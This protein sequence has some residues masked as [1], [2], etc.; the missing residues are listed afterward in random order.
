M[1]GNGNPYDVLTESRLAILRALH[2]V[3]TLDE[4]DVATGIERARL[5]AELEPL[6]EASLVVRI[7]AG[8]RPAF[9]IATREETDRVDNHAAEVGQRLAAHVSSHWAEIERAY[10]QLQVSRQ[11]SLAELS[12]VLVGD[13]ILDV[14]LLDALSSETRLMPPAPP[15]PSPS[16]PAARYYMWMIE[17]RHDQ[18]GRYGQRVT[19]LGAEGWSLLTFGQYTIDDE[20]NVARSDLEHR[21]CDDLAERSDRTPQDAGSAFHLPVVDL[22]DATAWWSFV[23]EF[24]TDLTRVYTSAESSLRDLYAS[25][26]ASGDPSD[27]FGEFFCW[28][29][30]LAYA[31]AIDALAHRGLLNI[32]PDRFVAALWREIPQAT[33]F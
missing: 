10:Q 20:L 7:E 17:G 32:P 21:V 11:F 14:G 24:A 2:G 8:F 1:A 16:D 9:L 25:L 29:D 23:R 12:F 22:D 13:R 4:L 18:L 3:A 33:R 30:H 6:C 26:A 15:R 19:G 31:H 5:I 28:Y 27:R